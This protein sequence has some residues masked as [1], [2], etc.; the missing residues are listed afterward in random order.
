MI[1]PTLPCIE[2]LQYQVKKGIINPTGNKNKS[3]LIFP[4]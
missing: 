2:L 4:Q 3:F 1:H